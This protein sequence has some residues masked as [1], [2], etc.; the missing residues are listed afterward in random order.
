M[1]HVKTLKMYLENVHI[2]HPIYVSNTLFNPKTVSIVLH[3]T[4]RWPPR[5]ISFTTLHR[6][7]DHVW[8]SVPWNTLWQIFYNVSFVPLLI[9]KE[10]LKTCYIIIIISLSCALFSFTKIDFN[11]IRTM[12]IG[13][14]RTLK[15]IPSIEVHPLSIWVSTRSKWVSIRSTWTRICIHFFHFKFQMMANDALLSQLLSFWHFN[16]T[17]ITRHHT[18]GGS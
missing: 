18:N 2:E 15:D 17:W 12:G 4:S 6:A 5:Y 9:K 10:V 13:T 3:S 1:I 14:N 16:P 7:G 11:R 8:L